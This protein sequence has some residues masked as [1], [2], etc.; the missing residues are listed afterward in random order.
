MPP[1]QEGIYGHSEENLAR[2]RGILWGAEASSWGFWIWVEI[3]P[4]RLPVASSHKL[5]SSSSWDILRIK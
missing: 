5:H 1:E 4:S 3:L 2:P